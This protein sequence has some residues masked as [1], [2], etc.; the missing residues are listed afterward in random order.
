MD[1]KGRFGHPNTPKTTLPSSSNARA[2]AYWPPL[3]K[4]NQV[5]KTKNM[6]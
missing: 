5:I 6:D 3:K 2:I 4:L 1:D